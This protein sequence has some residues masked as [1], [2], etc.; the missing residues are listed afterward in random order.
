MNRL[1][2]TSILVVAALA[3]GCKNNP[4][5]LDGWPNGV[6][7]LTQDSSEPA[8]GVDTPPPREPVT[9]TK[10]SPVIHELGPDA[11]VPTTIVIQLATAVID[12]ADVGMPTTKSKLKLVPDV[13]GTLTY[14]GVSELTFTPRGPLAFDTTTRSSSRRSRP[15]MA[16]SSTAGDQWGEKWHHTFKTPKFTFLGWAPTRPR[17]RQ[18]Q[19]DDGDRVLRRG[20]PEHRARSR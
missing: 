6:R 17:P 10:L 20:A 19:R 3:A 5:K 4:S 12:K 18:A 13:P 7:P 8:K 14:T 16:C 2:P 9:A 15:A 11:V 1:I